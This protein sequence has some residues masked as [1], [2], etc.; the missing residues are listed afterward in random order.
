M[1]LLGIGIGL[2]VLMLMA[3]PTLAQTIRTDSAKDTDFTQYKTF[4]WIKKPNATNPINNHRIVDAVNSA[5]NGK[6]L[7]LVEADG[8]LAIAANAATETE[9]TLQTFYD[10]FGGGWRWHDSF[11]S[12]TTTVT[13]YTVG[14]LVIDIFDTQSKTAVWRGTAMK[15]LSDRPEKVGRAIT[16]AIVKMFKR[17]PPPQ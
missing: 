1:R 10:G 17:Y 15:T 13:T 6:G 3:S 4:T 12:S 11:G 14:T 16:E 5:L 9:Q 8:D 7:K 2:G